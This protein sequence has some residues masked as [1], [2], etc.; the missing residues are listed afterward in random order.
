MKFRMW[1]LTQFP[2]LTSQMVLASSTQPGFFALVI[3]VIVSV[4]LGLR[5]VD[6]L[7]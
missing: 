7:S 5:A 4:E 2:K 1:E 6:I 3:S